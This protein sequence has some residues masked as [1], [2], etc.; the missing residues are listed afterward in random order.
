MVLAFVIWKDYNCDGWQTVGE[1]GITSGLQAADLLRM[2]VLEKNNAKNDVWS[3]ARRMTLDIASSFS[4]QVVS[5][6]ASQDI[7]SNI[8][9]RICVV[10][11]KVHYTK[12]TGVPPFREGGVAWGNVLMFQT[13]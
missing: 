4:G 1:N 2:F 6:V 9:G 8:Y 7:N 3:A 11:T 5:I 10:G 13:R 12:P